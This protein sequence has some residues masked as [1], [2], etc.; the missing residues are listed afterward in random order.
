[1][2]ALELDHAGQEEACLEQPNAVPEIAVLG[3]RSDV[4]QPR[5]KGM[6]HFQRFAAIEKWECS[7][8]TMLSWSYSWRQEQSRSIQ[9]RASSAAWTVG[10]Y[11]SS[12]TGE[13]P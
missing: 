2:D 9:I 5:D 13:R 3:R 6:T 11:R 8:G 1:M 4:Q 7:E 12:L 10:L